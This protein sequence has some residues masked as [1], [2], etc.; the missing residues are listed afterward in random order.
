LSSPAKCDLNKA[1]SVDPF[2]RSIALNE[3]RLKYGVQVIDPTP[4]LCTGSTCPAVLDGIVTYFDSYHI[5]E[6]MSVHLAP[7]FG[8]PILAKLAG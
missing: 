2:D 7:L 3:I 4:W 5:S 6:A 1:L 8:R